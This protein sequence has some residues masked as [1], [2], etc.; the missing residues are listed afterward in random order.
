MDSPSDTDII[1]AV[2]RGDKQAFATLVDRYRQGAYTLALRI[3]QDKDTAED[4]TQEAFI[5]AYE[6][7]ARFS[8]KARFST[9]LY[10]I[11]YNTAISYMRK[12][13]REAGNVN[14]AR[15]PEGG[16]AGDLSAVNSLE[17]EELRL[18]LHRALAALP[19]N[20]RVALT[21]FYLHE[22]S[23][24][25]IARITG[26]SEANI[27]ILLHRGRKNLRQRLHL[28]LGNEISEIL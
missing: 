13:G 22:Q 28:L 7:L 4:I 9:W 24:K 17:N 11:V 20:E 23:I 15:L 18:W 3:L 5:K 2:V 8:G 25:E 19:V 26:L 10:R 27:K 12:S 14:T 16:Q 1:K 21:L 6:N